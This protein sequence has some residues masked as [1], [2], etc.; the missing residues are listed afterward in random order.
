MCEAENIIN[1]C[2]ISYCSDDPSDLESLTPNH[3]L[4]LKPPCGL[5]PGTFC[6][7]DLSSRKHWREFQ[8]L[9]N[10]F[11]SRWTKETYLCCKHD[12]IKFQPFNRRHCFNH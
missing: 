12:K 4:Q 2:P 3:F 11:W 9:I 5:P 6:R 8:Y 1:S 7:H 10:V